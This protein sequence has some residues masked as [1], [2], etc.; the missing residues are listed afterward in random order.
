[1]RAFVRQ[2]G[3]VFQKALNSRQV[4]RVLRIPTL[5]VNLCLYFQWQSERWCQPS[6][7]TN[8]VAVPQHESRLID[9]R[10]SVNDLRQSV[11]VDQRRSE[12]FFVEDRE[13]FIEAA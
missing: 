10:S 5:V 1:M 13:I 2:G 11:P 8:P 9:V 3:G 7:L 6:D 12:W 4:D